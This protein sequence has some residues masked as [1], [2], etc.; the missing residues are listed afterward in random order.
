MVGI[1]ILKKI[2][3]L[4]DLSDDILEKIGG[5]AQLETFDEE[6]ILVRQDQKLHLIYMLVTG[7]IFSNCR[8]ASGKALTLDELSP[9]QTFGVSALMGDS[10]ATFTA[11]CAEECTVITLS[12]DQM[13]QLFEQDF[14]LGYVV[15]QQVVEL[16]KSKMNKHTRQFLHSLATHPAM[17]EIQKDPI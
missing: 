2:H 4:Q 3:F 16:F 8:S 14:K 7:K 9:G 17:G 10:L 15:M 13:I 6:A 5:I 11:I 12:S 1:D